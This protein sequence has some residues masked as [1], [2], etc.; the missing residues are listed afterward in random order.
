MRRFIIENSTALA[1]LAFVLLGWVA[2]DVA[3]KAASPKG[4]V[5]RTVDLNEQRQI[6]RVFQITPRIQMRFSM[7]PYMSADGKRAGYV[8]SIYTIVDNTR[9][10]QMWF[11]PDEEFLKLMDDFSTGTEVVEQ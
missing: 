1:A 9:N 8:K 4:R 7:S 3:F 6:L 2:F 5:S 10:E 11:G